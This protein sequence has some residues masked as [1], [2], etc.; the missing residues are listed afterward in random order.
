MVVRA[1]ANIS[2]GDQLLRFYGELTNPEAAMVYG[3]VPPNNIRSNTI[4]FASAEEAAKY[5]KQRVLIGD[6]EWTH[7]VRSRGVSRASAGVP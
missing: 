1:T 6:T 5:Y 3:F 2:R 7:N 4:L